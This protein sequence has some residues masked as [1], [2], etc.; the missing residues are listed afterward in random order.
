M[1]LIFQMLLFFL[2]GYLFI[3]LF[4]YLRQGAFIFFPTLARHEEH[5][6]AN[7]VDYQLERETATLRGWLV[8]PE[9]GEGKTD[10]LLRR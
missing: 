1:S 6:F 4:M 3:M 8:N 2:I 9:S 10:H 5:G 7:V